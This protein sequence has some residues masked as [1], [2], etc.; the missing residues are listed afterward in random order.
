M[1][2]CS[3]VIGKSI[4]FPTGDPTRFLEDIQILKPHFVAL[5]PR[6]LNRL[7]QSANAAATAPGFK[8]MLFR[9][10]VATKLEN[11]ASSGKLTHALWD[12]LVFRKA[13][14][15]TATRSHPTDITHRSTP[16]S[17]GDS[18][19]SPQARRRWGST[20]RTSSRSARSSTSARA[21]A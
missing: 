21:T 15:S 6:V 17:A 3:V 20:S 16:S 19:R 10:A 13:R 8:G 2:L 18:R 4:G 11:L 1:D 12:R 7:Y 14:Q 9:R 5:V